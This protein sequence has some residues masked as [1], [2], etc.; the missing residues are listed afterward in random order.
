MNLCF[1]HE[2]YPPETNYGGIATYQKIVAEYFA[3][4]GDNVTVIAAGKKIAF[5]LITKSKL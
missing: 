2:E 5:M 1:V 4:H 3:N